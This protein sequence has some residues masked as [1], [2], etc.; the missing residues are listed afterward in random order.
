MTSPAKLREAIYRIVITQLLHLRK[1]SVDCGAGPRGQPLNGGAG[2]EVTAFN[3]A[4]DSRIKQVFLV[5]TKRFQEPQ[6]C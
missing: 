6:I 5:L 1:L 4:T 3:A 2:S